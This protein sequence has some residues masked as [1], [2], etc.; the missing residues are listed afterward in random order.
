MAG[1]ALGERLPP[2][3]GQ[4]PPDEPEIDGGIPDTDVALVKHSAD[5]VAVDHD[6][7]D[8]ITG[9]RDESR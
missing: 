4:Q 7:G 8:E 1:A 6:A 5:G 3:G 2:V 9:S